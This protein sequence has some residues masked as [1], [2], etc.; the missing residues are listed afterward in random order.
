MME[1]RLLVCG[2]C[3]LVNVGTTCSDCGGACI[4]M[5]TGRPAPSGTW[6]RPSPPQATS[7]PLVMSNT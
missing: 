5:P 3:R 4:P 7:G 2:D 6:V 1:T